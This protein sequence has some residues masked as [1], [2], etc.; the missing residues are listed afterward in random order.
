MTAIV[1]ILLGLVISLAVSTRIFRRRWRASEEQRTIELQRERYQQVELM[2]AESTRMALLLDGMIEGLVELDASGRVMLANRA[3]EK[4]FGFSR[5]LA[6]RTVL[7]LLRN[8]DV[9]ALASRALVAAEPIEEEVQLEGA[10]RRVLQISAVALHDAKGAVSGAVLVF[11]DITR[12]RQL[13]SVRQD[14]VANVS[15]E[16]RTPLSVMKSAAETLLDGGMNDATVATRFLGIIDKHASR[17]GL[18]IDDLL[19]LSRLDSEHLT[20]KLESLSLHGVVQEVLNNFVSQ[21]QVRGASLHNRVPPEIFVR[22]DPDRFQQ[23]VGNLIDNAV[24]HGRPEGQILVRARVLNYER[25]EVS[26][27]DD[28][29]GIPVEAQPRIFERFYRVDKARS[30][31]QGGTGL[32]LAIVKNLVLAHGGVVRV[33]STPGNG[34]EFFFTL[35]RVEN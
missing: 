14:F 16:L 21:A 9:A 33:E 18:L 8:R 27:R 30:R 7:D 13:E 4:M 25:V 22:A 2:H 32:G 3:A 10:T 5:M 11:R 28:G 31:E 26:V 1:L 17:L 6:G 35:S 23:I 20:L 15:H 12:L 19:L 24:K 34:T 29:P